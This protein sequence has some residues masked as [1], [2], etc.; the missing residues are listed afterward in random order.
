[1]DPTGLGLLLF[2]IDG[3]VTDPQGRV[4]G[5]VF[6]ALEELRA[7]GVPCLPVTGR[8]GGWC[9]L[10]ARTWPVDGVI[11]ENGGLAFRTLGHGQ[12]MERFFWQG[13]DERRSNRERLRALAQ[14]I[15]RQV[16][17]CALASDQPYRDLDLAVDFCED[18]PPLSPAEV[19]RI[20][21]MFRDAGATH[22]VSSIHVNGWFGDWDKRGMVI[23]IGRRWFGMDL[24]GR[25]RGAAV[26]LGDSP[27]DEPM[28]EHFPRACAVANLRDFLPRLRHA[29]AYLCTGDGADGFVELVDHLLAASA[30]PA[31]PQG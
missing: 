26:F 31:P 2:D 25:D 21:R 30:A 7:A 16:P 1:L 14:D 9:D 28:F 15:L 20:E 3:T 5:K 10:I 24:D 13:P 27:N 18:V 12:P 11:G 22:K 6:A 8:P 29:P 17:G 19:G 23:E 4:P